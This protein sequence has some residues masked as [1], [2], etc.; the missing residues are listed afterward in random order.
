[1][2]GIVPGDGYA[3]WGLVWTY[4]I[5]C[6]MWSSSRPPVIFLQATPAGGPLFLDHYIFYVVASPFN[7]ELLDEE[8][9]WKVC[10]TV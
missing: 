2:A 3:V 4:D 1:M 9:E 8:F 6:L 7:F 10:L 5:C